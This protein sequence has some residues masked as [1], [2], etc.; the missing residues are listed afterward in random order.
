MRILGEHAARVAGLDRLPSLQA[1][2][3]FLGRDVDVQLAVFSVDGDLVAVLDDAKRS[4]GVGFGSDM[5]DDE[6][7]RA[8][9]ESSV[10]DQGHVV[11]ESTSH[12]C[13]CRPEHFTHSGAAFGAFIPN[14]D[15]IALLDSACENRLH[16]QF[17]GIVDLCLSSEAQSLL[18]RD[19]GDGTGRGQIAVKNDEMA[20]F[21]DRFVERANDG[22]AFGVGFHLLQR[23]GH[24]LA[25]D[26]KAVAMKQSGVEQHFHQRADSADGDQFGHEVSAAGLQVGQI[27]HAFPDP[28]EIVQREFHI[29]GAGDGEQVQ[30]GVG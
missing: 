24:R 15:H 14:D 13:G 25:G 21:L 28:G 3:Q 2:L 7:V 5:A 26:G 29:G 27:G 20:V 6:S 17:L 12:D 19:F 10:G 30:H 18:A 1:S 16:G 8:A 4:A 11:A 22:L 23:L 9:G